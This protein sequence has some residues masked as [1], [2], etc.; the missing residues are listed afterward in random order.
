MENTA[1][2][3]IALLFITIFG[4]LGGVMFKFGTNELG[5]ISFSRMTEFRITTSSLVYGTMLVAG[6]VLFVLGGSG[7]RPWSFAANYLFTP[8]IFAALVM[9]AVS[10]FL[11]G[12]PLSVTG[13][14]RFSAILMATGVVATAIASAVVFRES[15][16]IRT[17]A[18]IALAAIAVFLIG[19]EI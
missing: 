18:G 4:T 1:V 17:I 10:R 15:F 7:L 16:S 9:L 5:S 12:I 3:W 2:F 14:G 19:E 6:L 11:V 13:L 8:V